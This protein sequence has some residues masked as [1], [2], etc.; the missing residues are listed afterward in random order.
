MPSSSLARTALDTITVTI[1]RSR[2]HVIAVINSSHK[3]SVIDLGETPE[4]FCRNGAR[5][6]SA[7]CSNGLRCAQL[8]RRA[9]LAGTGFVTGPHPNWP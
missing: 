9:G 5:S 6:C 4:V 8:A 7:G 3:P 1:A 2:W